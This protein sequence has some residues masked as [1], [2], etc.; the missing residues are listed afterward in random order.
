LPSPHVSYDD[1]RATREPDWRFG[2]WHGVG[3]GCEDRR[4]DDAREWKDHAATMAHGQAGI[5][6][7]TIDTSFIALIG[8][9][10]TIVHYLFKRFLAKVGNLV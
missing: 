7:K 8:I 9:V 2:V 6:T 3:D 1:R 5:A 10:L 4:D